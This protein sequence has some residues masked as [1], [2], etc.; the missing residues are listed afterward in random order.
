MTRIIGASGGYRKTLSFGF[1]CLVCH[2]TFAFCRR[3][4]NLRNDPLGKAS[5]QM[6]G[7]ARSARQNIV[8]GSARVGRVSSVGTSRSCRPACRIARNAASQC[9]RWLRK[10]GA[11]QGILFG[12]ARDIPTAME[13]ATT[14]RT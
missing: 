8:E 3:N 7:A 13:R 9:A 4:Y 2:A 1:T 10:R 14:W 6:V 5:G 11:T 12:V